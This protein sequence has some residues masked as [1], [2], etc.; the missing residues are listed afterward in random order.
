MGACKIF[1][2]LCTVTNTDAR[3]RS[4]IHA[5]THAHKSINVP[6]EK[7]GLRTKS[8]V[9]VHTMKRRM[10][11]ETTTCAQA[12]PPHELSRGMHCRQGREGGG[13]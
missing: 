5:Y 3:V 10:D 8:G 6:G 13:E 7:G 12:P 4:Q 11:D 1:L 2:S 9:T